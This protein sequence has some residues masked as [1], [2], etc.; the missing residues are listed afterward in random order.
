MKENLPSN[1]GCYL[2]K[3]SSNNIIYVGKAKNLKK[4]VDSY[5]N[6]KPDDSK[7]H[8]L[9][10]E[11]KEVDFVVTDNEI[12][13]LILEDKLIKKNQ[14]KYNIMLKDNDYYSYIM[15][16][17]EEFPRLLT[18]RKVME[19]KNR[20]F[21]PYTSARSRT[22][23]LRFLRDVFKI[24]TCGSP[25]PKR[26]CLRYHIGR[27]DAPCADHINK[28]DYNLLVERAVLFLKG[29]NKDLLKQ[30]KKEMKEASKE[31]RYERAMTLRDQLD[32]IQRINKK[33]KIEL[34]KTFDLDIINYFRDG[35]RILI[36]VFNMN[37]G[38]MQNQRRFEFEYIENVFNDFLKR[39]YVSNPIPDEIIVPR[40]E[41]ESL[42]EYLSKLKDKKVRVQ[43]PVKGDKKKLLELVKKNAKIHFAG[44]SK[45]AME[46]KDKL[47][48]SRLPSVIDCFDVSNIQGDLATGSAVRF[49]NGKPDKMQ[50]RKFKIRGVTGAN[51]PAMMQEI[52]F[53]RY[54]RILEEGS[55]LPDLIIVDGGK[56]QLSAAKT[57]LKNINLNLDL[58]SI[59]KKEEEVYL[60]GRKTPVILGSK[61]KGRHL[62]QNIRDEA[63]RFAVTYHKYLRGKKAIEHR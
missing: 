41:D 61:S 43:A 12:E 20:Y 35:H 19:D 52:V 55:D 54:S 26:V 21:G 57:A 7:T 38:V 32:A 51:D 46:L 58:V 6:K 15:V 11:I 37:R 10:L 59:A 34:S 53:R 30:L 16:T 23:V 56:G 49:V 27:C 4:R 48:L 62:I 1:P 40:I 17:N 50:Y 14:P 3:D 22:I 47:R 18:V 9:V 45:E 39:Y 33:Q 42:E 2:F 13:A 5:F 24:R 8:N 63:H 28:E 36:E 29:M 60:I 31:M 44:E 25:I